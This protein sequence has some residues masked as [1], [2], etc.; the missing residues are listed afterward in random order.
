M[1][2]LALA[3]SWMLLASTTAAVGQV[4]EEDPLDPYEVEAVVVTARRIGVP[5]WR[6]GHGSSTLILVGEIQGVPEDAPWRPAELESVV[7]QADRVVF[8]HNVSASPADIAR[9]LWRT[10]SIVFLPKG[11]TLADYVDAGTLARLEAVN[12]AADGWAT[13]PNL[14]PWMVADELMTAAGAGELLGEERVAEVVAK[15]VRK[16][17]KKR[18]VVGRYGAGRVVDAYL[19]GPGQ[20]VACL[21]AAIDTAEAGREASARRIADWTRSRV[22]DVIA[23][24]AERAYDL[25]WPFGAAPARLRAD[26][27]AALDRKLAAPGVTVA[28]LPLLFLAENGGLLDGLAARGLDISGPRWRAEARSG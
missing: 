15:A 17:K 8:P 5:V 21:E 2:T 4:R 11:K 1:R 20:H 28:V 19:V 13:R 16:H 24:P 14:H 10:R 9:M 23:S 7:A 3:V 22:P 18:E 26:W 6:V 27:R 25:C 12:Q